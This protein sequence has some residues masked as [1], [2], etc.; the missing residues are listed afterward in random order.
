MKKVKTFYFLAYFKH[1][2]FFQLCTPAEVI[3]AV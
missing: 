3:A 2:A 1:Y